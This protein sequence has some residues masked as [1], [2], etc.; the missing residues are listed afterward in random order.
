MVA[1]IEATASFAVVRRCADLAELL[2]TAAAGLGEV[3]LVSADLRA[4]DRA[5]LAELAAHGVHV[6][7]AIDRDDES[8]ERRLR[9]LGLAV[10]VTAELAPHELDDALDALCAA[11]RAPGAHSELGPHGELGRAAGSAALVSPTIPRPSRA[12]CPH[13]ASAGA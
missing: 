13:R 7:G 4:L 8:G 9:Q 5:A 10:V 12:T 6:A 1:A 2:A 3:A 11:D